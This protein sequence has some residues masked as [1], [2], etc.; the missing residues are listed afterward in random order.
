MVYPGHGFGEC[1]C[2]REA[3]TNKVAMQSHYLRFAV[4]FELQVCSA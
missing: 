3:I 1:G 4:H 2:G